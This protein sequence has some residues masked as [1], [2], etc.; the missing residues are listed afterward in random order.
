MDGH[1]PDVVG[2]QNSAYR[3]AR[4][5]NFLGSMGGKGQV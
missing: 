2:E 4:P 1:H 5:E 3:F